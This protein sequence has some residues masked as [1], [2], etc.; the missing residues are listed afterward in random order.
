MY[1]G[2]P[3]QATT[4]SI[5]LFCAG[6]GI[7]EMLFTY[8]SYLLDCSGLDIGTLCNKFA[9]GIGQ[10]LP[11]IHIQSLVSRV[12]PS[13]GNKTDA[14]ELIL[15]LAVYLITVHPSSG[16]SVPPPHDLQSVYFMAKVCLTKVQMASSSTLKLV[17]AAVLISTYEYS[18]RKLESAFMTIETCVVMANLLELSPVGPEITTQQVDEVKRVKAFEECNVSWGIVL[19][20]RQAHPAKI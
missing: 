2:T 15:L 8:L 11:V 17:Q 4:W 6:E 9:A 16:N 14:D 7:P 20:E 13:F 5:D 18:S 10:W 19:M 12:A 3:S 1:D